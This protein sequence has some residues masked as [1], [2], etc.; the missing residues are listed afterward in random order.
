MSWAVLIKQF[1]IFRS[2]IK[3]YCDVSVSKIESANFQRIQLMSCLGKDIVRN[4]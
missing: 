1:R 3:V 2:L 4:N